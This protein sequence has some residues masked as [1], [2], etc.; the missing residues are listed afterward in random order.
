[1]SK[2]LER[3]KPLIIAGKKAKKALS[4]GLGQY[5]ESVGHKT[6]LSEYAG[7]ID[8]SDDEFE[9]MLQELKEAN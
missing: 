5:V 9:A 8:F 1:M 6:S 4:I 3:K 7:S 2:K